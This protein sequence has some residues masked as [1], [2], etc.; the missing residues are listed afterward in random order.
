[1]PTMCDRTSLI[2]AMASRS[3]GTEG[4]WVG[5]LRVEALASYRKPVL[6]DIPTLVNI[7]L[8]Q[9]LNSHESKCVVSVASSLF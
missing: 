6:E 9:G 3:Q 5:H 1:M 7:F 4:D 2:T 8:G